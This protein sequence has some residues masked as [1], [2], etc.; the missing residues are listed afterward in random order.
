VNQTDRGPG[1]LAA[2]LVEELVVALTNS[3]IYEPAH[4]RVRLPLENAAGFL[5]R[6]L[7][8][9]GGG[10]L[11]LRVQEGLF[12]F[13]G[14]PLLGV[15][16]QA[17]RMIQALQAAG[18]GGFS[19]G[20]QAGREDLAALVGLLGGEGRPSLEAAQEELRRQGA[21]AVRLLPPAVG[22]HGAWASEDNDLPPARLSLSLHQ[23]LLG[24][25]QDV[26]VRA[27]TG[28]DLG[29]GEITLQLERA[30]RLMAREEMGLMRL[31]RYE[32]YDAFTFGHSL[33]VCLLAMNFGRKLEADEETIL[34]I[35][36]AA[37][38]HDIGK[39]RVPFEI[40]H[41]TGRLSE[42]E[43]AEMRLHPRHGAE[44]LLESSDPDPMAV[45]VAFGHH[46]G[47][48]GAGYPPL[49]HPTAH[50]A[51]T[52]IVKICD[53]YEALTAVRPYKAPLAP[54]SA[55]KIM[56]GMQGA[57]D[58]ALLGRFIA[59]NGL[60]PTGIRVRL[61]DGRAARVYRQSRRIDRPLVALEGDEEAVLDLC[62]PEGGGATVAATLPEEEAEVP[63][64]G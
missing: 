56:L 4:A 18:I 29:L 46:Q 7:S 48:G 58:Q 51:A 40:V 19:L 31:A 53:V 5:D 8:A 17:P 26:S 55:Y 3:R 34:R 42:A 63:L 57:F 30:L 33:Q 13:Q 49:R 41:S 20:P 23:G 1:H 14:R 45:A 6:A 15:S 54:P 25:L 39:T 16:L 43:M 50:G 47:E 9:L 64:R 27:G 11:E 60:F 28:R 38:L 22:A 35:G 37:F 36:R 2:R 52:K 44:I 12:L 62:S 61:S 24:L 21:A 59:A 32:R 10:A